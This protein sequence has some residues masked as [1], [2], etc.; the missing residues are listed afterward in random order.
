MAIRLPFF[1]LIAT[2]SPLSGLLEHYEQVCKA[3]V[4]IEEAMECYIADSSGLACKEFPALQEELDAVEEHADIITRNLRNHVPRSIFLPI[5]K[6]LFFLYTRSQDD[7]LDYGYSSVQWLGMR[8]VVVPEEFHRDLIFFLSDSLKTVELLGPALEI[9]IDWM[10]SE[11]ISRE[12][13]KQNF[14]AVRKHHKG[15]TRARQNIVPAIYRSDLDFKD[16]YQLIHCMDMLHNM[17]HSAMYCADLLR[18]MIAK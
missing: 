5:D 12:T 15:V 2:R 9:T 14:W 17:S 18:V 7:I 11:T 1:G 4:L 10:T 3:M 13:A 6:H 16:I 8:N